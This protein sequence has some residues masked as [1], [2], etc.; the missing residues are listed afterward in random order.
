MRKGKVVKNKKL[1]IYQVTT[2]LTIVVMGLIS[3]TFIFIGSIKN[4]KKDISSC[5]EWKYT[6]DLIDD[7]VILFGLKNEN[8]IESLIVIKLSPVRKE[9]LCVPVPITALCKLNAKNITLEKLY[10]S[11]GAA[12]LAKGVSNCL[13]I[14]VERYMLM[15][16]N[17]FNKAVDYLGGVSLFLPCNLSYTNK[18]TG[19]VTNFLANGRKEIYDGTALRK[20]ITYPLYSKGEEFKSQINGNVVVELINNG[21]SFKETLIKDM[22]NI[23]NDY[24]KNCLTNVTEYDYNQA[25]NAYRYLISETTKPATYIVISGE[26]KDKETFII[27]DEYKEKLKKYLYIE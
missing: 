11:E 5:T 21:I 19:E 27:S 6:P 1:Y 8:S 14:N 22:D 4:R 24:I 20:I 23:A 10:K 9:L 2:I 18:D 7:R 17:Y 26:L 13:D 16:Y 3:F 15:D 25:K 12:S